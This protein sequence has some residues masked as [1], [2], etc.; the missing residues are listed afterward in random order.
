MLGAT[1]GMLTACTSSQPG[2]HTLRP[3]SFPSPTKCLHCTSL[4]LGLGR[5]GLGCD[6]KN[7][8]FQV[9]PSHCSPG[10]DPDTPRLF[11]T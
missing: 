6:S 1:G 3:R 8:L 4:M 9:L 2:S 11:S 10:H 7:L 5:Q